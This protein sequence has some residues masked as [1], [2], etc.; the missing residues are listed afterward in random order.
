MSA[1][2]CLSFLRQG[3]DVLRDLWQHQN[4]ATGSGLWPH[5]YYLSMETLASLQEMKFR[6]Y[7][8]LL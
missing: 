3:E 7:P 4:F 8:T 6:R 2:E 5:K 1:K